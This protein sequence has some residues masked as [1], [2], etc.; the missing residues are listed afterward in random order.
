VIQYALLGE[1]VGACPQSAMPLRRASSRAKARCLAFSRHAE[2]PIAN[3]TLSIL[4]QP[5]LDRKKDAPCRTIKRLDFY[6]PNGSC[7]LEP[8]AARRLIEEVRPLMAWYL[9]PLVVLAGFVAGFMNTLAGSGSLVTLPVLIFLGLPVTIANGTNRVG[10]LFQNIVGTTSFRRGGLLDVR[11]SLILG[12]PAVLGS[13]AGA[14]IAVR[15]DEA[16]MRTTIGALMLVMLFIILLRPQRWLRGTLH[17]LD[18]WPKWWLLGLFFLIGLYGGFIQAGVGI[19]LLAGLVLG[20]GYDLVKANAVKIAIVL[21]FTISA[22]T[23]FVVHDQVDWVIGL[24]L[25]V[26][27]MLGAWVAARMAIERGAVWVRRLLILVVAISAAE[28]LGLGDVFSRLL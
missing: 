2:H 10:I 14:Q 15:L 4:A 5:V 12:V 26:G 7:T 28:L 9:Y 3:A 16:T 22:I 21:L 18:H 13:I 20:V 23:V 8:A 25:S 6:H 1:M 27:N 11:G 17:Q 24:V 19:F